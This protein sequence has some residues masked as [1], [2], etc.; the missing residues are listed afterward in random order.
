MYGLVL[1]NPDVQRAHLE[2]VK[3]L[4]EKSPLG[5]IGHADEIAGTVAFL[6]SDASTYITGQNIMVDGGRTAW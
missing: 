2:F 3:R 1:P 5:R 4:S 6:L